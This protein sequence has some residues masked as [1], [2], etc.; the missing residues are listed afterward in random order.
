MLLILSAAVVGAVIGSFLGAAQVR[1]PEG[2]SVLS[3]RSACDTC[4]KQLTP[5]E[6][7]PVVSWLVQRGVCR[8]CGAARARYSA[9]R[10]T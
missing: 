3:G 1:L 4:D 5:M 7:V 6:L 10:S 2:R 8:S 9:S